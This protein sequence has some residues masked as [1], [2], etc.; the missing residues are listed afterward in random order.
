MSEAFKKAA[1]DAKKLPTKPSN[2]D[3]LTLYSLF[4][5]AEFGDCNTVRPGMLDFQGKAKWDAW[6]GKKGLSKED[7]QTQYVAEVTRLQAS[8]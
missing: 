5:Q 2:E 6:D 7:A 8:K 3:L 4:K 1:D